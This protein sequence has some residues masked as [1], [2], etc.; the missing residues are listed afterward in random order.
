MLFYLYGIQWVENNVLAPKI[1]GETT[2]IHPITILL[3]LIIGGGVFGV[4]G[5]I[6]SVP[7]VAIFKIFLGFLW[8]K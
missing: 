8:R 2:G 7:V 6:F 4:M 1:I 5:M 3:A